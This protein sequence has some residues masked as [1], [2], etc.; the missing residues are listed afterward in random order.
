ML[1]LSFGI[2]YADLHQREGLTRLDA[3]FLDFVARVGPRAA[4]RAARGTRRARGA[5]AEGGIRTADRAGAAARGLRGA[6]V[7]HRDR[8][9]RAGRTAP[10]AGADVQRQTPVRAAPGAGEVQ[11]RGGRG[12]R[13]RRPRQQTLLGE[14]FSELAFAR[15]VT[16]WQ[17]DE[18]ANAGQ[19][20]LAARY[21]AWAA[22]TEA[23]RARHRDGVLFKAPAKLDY[24]NLVPLI[25]RETLGFPRHS[26]DHLR[27]R[28]GFALTDH[29]T[30]LA[31]ALDEANYCI[32]CHN[33]GK[34]SCSHGLREKA[35]KG[36]DPASAPFKKSPFGVTLA[37]CP[38]E[39]KISE[40]HLVKTR[41]E[42]HRRAGDHRGRQPDG[43]RH[44]A[45]HLQRLHEVLHLPEAGAGGHSAGRDAHAEGCAGA[46]VGLRDLRAADALEP[47]EPAPSA[48]AARHRAQGAGGGPGAG[49]LHA[50]APPDER[51]PHGGRH[52]RAEDRAAAAPS[53]PASRSTASACLRA[54]ARRAAR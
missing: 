38:L 3:Q 39:E 51:R 21:A 42:R 8:G 28:E 24:Q 11:A 53:S 47:A 17:E 35:P 40:F 45:P 26:I 7:R 29:G 44:R 2:E 27:R 15:R 52:R 5:R 37:G 43:G 13:R 46:A 34:D 49:R 30:D 32:W 50:R 16:A 48:A 54:G 36:A 41:G 4:R 20:E 22:G 18:A 9:A 19:L 1:K 10:R 14:P 31:G 23:G 25:T 33:Q 12:P 6:A